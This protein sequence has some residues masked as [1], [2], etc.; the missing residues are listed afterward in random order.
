MRMVSR[1]LDWE[2][3]FLNEVKLTE[4]EPEEDYLEDVQKRKKQRR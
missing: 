2:E 1:A 4:T 3:I